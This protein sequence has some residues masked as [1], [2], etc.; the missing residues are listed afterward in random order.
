M[1]HAPLLTSMELLYSEIAEL[2]HRQCRNRAA[3]LLK[4]KV[5]PDL[6][7]S[8][9]NFH[10][11]ESIRVIA[12]SIWEIVHICITFYVSR[13]ASERFT[14][15]HKCMYSEIFFG[16]VE[17]ESP[18]LEMPQVLM[19][20]KKNLTWMR[21]LDLNMRFICETE[22]DFVIESYKE[23]CRLRSDMSFL[24]HNQC[25]LFIAELTQF[26]LNYL[27]LQCGE[28]D[29]LTNLQRFQD[30]LKEYKQTIKKTKCERP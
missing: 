1:T 19:P 12:Y 3:Q 5:I 6:L 27:K 15:S 4:I 14:Q 17:E 26:L 18:F 29:S 16:T 9:K 23:Y 30:L 21:L 10:D 11:G 20:F 13:A 24:T 28:K 7:N 22:H 8:I 25:V 2:P